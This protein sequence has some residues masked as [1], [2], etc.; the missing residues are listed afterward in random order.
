MNQVETIILSS[1][2]VLAVVK[3]LQTCIPMLREILVSRKKQLISTRSDLNE[4]MK[5]ARRLYEDANIAYFNNFD[6]K[7]NW[8]VYAK[9]LADLEIE[10]LRQTH[11]AQMLELEVEYAKRE[12]ELNQEIAMMKLN[13]L[14]KEFEAEVQK[15]GDVDL[16]KIISL[17]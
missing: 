8:L 11:A 13:A 10:R 6:R 1:A 16:T 14:F 9:E 3:I 4:Q 7:V 5:I 12:M 2:I 15:H 17:Q